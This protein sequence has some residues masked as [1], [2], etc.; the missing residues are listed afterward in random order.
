MRAAMTMTPATSD[1]V[2]S[3]FGV[4][5]CIL[6]STNN[7]S[8]HSA[9]GMTTWRSNHTA[10]WLDDNIQDFPIFV[11]TLLRLSQSAGSILK[12]A[13]DQREVNSKKAQLERMKTAVAKTREVEQRK[14]YQLI[15]LEGV[16]T[17][18]RVEDVG[19]ALNGRTAANVTKTIAEQVRLLQH[20]HG[21]RRK[22]LMSFSVGGSRHS[23]SLVRQ[24][25]EQLVKRIEDGTLQVRPA[26]SIEDIVMKNREVFRGDVLTET[27]VQSI[28]D[29]HKYY[30]K[31]IEDCRE[32]RRR[33][34]A[35]A[36]IKSGKKKRKK[37]KNKRCK[38]KEDEDGRIELV[39]RKVTMRGDVWFMDANLVFTGLITKREVYRGR[40][41]GRDRKR[42]DGY[43][44]QWSD[45]KRENWP[46][47]SL[48][49]CLIPLP[50]RSTVCV[51]A[52]RQEEVECKISEY[53]ETESDKGQEKCVDDPERNDYEGMYMSDS[54]EDNEKIHTE[55]C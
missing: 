1:R 24:M 31:M 47:E 40:G 49:P 32:K 4:L 43:E 52:L 19:P 53:N 2:E 14:I 9:G 38:K 46:Y 51:S 5:D 12:K 42:V 30:V 6:S 33:A 7:L 11:T 22:N 41:K 25:Y 3:S 27:A 37:S 48:L 50:S 36:N 13:A 28:R 45:G 21:C 20:R 16:E 18:L 8:L 17:I 39:G 35:S 54:G 34:S 10:Q 44:V 29:R 15:D 55:Y 23:H 26:R